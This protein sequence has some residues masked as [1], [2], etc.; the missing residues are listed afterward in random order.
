MGACDGPLDLAGDSAGGCYTQL[1]YFTTGRTVTPPRQ[2]FQVMA[3]SPAANATNVGLRTPVTATF[4]R[5]IN[6]G[7]VNQ[8][9]SDFALF[10][11]R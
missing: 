1:I 11:R 3:F 7:T 10:I 5:S 8:Q 2:P 6:L 9:R 4:N